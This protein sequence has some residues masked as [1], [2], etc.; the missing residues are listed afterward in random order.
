MIPIYMIFIP[1]PVKSDNP[2]NADNE[3]LDDEDAYIDDPELRN[4]VSSTF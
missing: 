1:S 3:A 2:Y 4:S